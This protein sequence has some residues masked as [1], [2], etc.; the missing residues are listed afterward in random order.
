MVLY[1]WGYTYAA[2]PDAAEQ[3][4]VAGKVTAALE[5]VAGASFVQG[6]SAATIYPTSGDITDWAYGAMGITHVMTI[7]GRDLGMNGFVAPPELIVPAGREILS[8]LVVGAQ[9]I[10]EPASA[11]LLPD[12]FC[13]PALREAPPPPPAR[14]RLECWL[15]GFTHCR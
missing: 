6:P 3:G 15:W 10:R 12:A 5:C 4:D 8:G 14:C 13:S 1:P 11:D 7:E 9:Y 2:S